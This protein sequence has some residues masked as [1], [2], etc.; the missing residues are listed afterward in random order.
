MK[1]NRPVPADL[2]SKIEASVEKA[3]RFEFKRPIGINFAVGFAVLAV[4]SFFYTAQFSNSFNKNDV[5]SY[6][7][8]LHVEL[9]P[10]ASENRTSDIFD[11]I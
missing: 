3:S 2:W 7:Y 5:N 9:Y 8:E 6:L 10:D 11:L 1:T 4:I